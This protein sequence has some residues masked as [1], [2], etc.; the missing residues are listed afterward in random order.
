M[1]NTAV[2]IN[3]GDYRQTR[4]VKTEVEPLADG[5]ARVE[6]EKFALT[7]NNV[8][9]AASGDLF[10]YWRFYPTGEDPWGAVTV[11]GIARV[12]ESATDSI[13]EG[14][15]IYGFFPMSRYVTLDPGNVAEGGFD[16]VAAHRQSLPAL[17]NHYARLGANSSEV[18]SLEDARCLYFP[19]FITGFVIADLLSDNDWYGSRQILI[20][21]ASSK[22]GFST[23]AFLRAAGFGGR[24]V[25]LTAEANIDFCE[26]LGFY[27]HVQ[28]YA[29]T[30]S[31]QSEPAV[32]VDMSGNAEGRSRL[33]Q[34][35]QEN[36]KRSIVV[37]ATH[38]NDFGASLSPQ[39]LPGTPPEVFFA[40]AQIEKRDGEWGSGVMM[41]RGY[42]ASAAL[43]LSLTDTLAVE[44]HNGP[45]AL[46]ALW[47]QMLDNKISGRSGLMLSLSE[48]FQ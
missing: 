45:N 25:G 9:Y 33:H 7:A 27:D 36:M 44:Y 11:W 24:I 3:R 18:V 12:L 4:V 38:W 2:W 21:S 43:A 47:G 35:L 42:E 31:V 30:M 14:E 37:G 8:T 6:V 22:T 15:R 23:A 46:I 19:L 40:P 32:F 29:E 13:V 10:G 48:H 34:H 20:S 41:K 28:P 16:D 39:N 1:Q 26:E 17:Y 5:Q